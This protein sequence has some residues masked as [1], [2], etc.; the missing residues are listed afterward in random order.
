MKQFRI[1]LTLLLFTLH[2]VTLAQEEKK[3]EIYTSTAGAI[4]GYDV[5]AYFNEGKPVLGKPEFTFTWKGASWYF[6]GQANMET[7]KVNPEKYAPMYGGYCAFGMS[8]G[9]K[10]PTEPDAWTIVE[11]KLYLNYN[12]KVQQTWIGNQKEFIEKANLNW[13]EIR[14]Q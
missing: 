7:F 11:G 3:P 2:V 4:N 1:T 13:P 9:Y 6:S 14:Q 8:R 12:T 5:V 10:A